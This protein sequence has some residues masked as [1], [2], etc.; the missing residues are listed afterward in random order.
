MHYNRAKFFSAVR[1]DFGSLK[2]S[3]VDGFNFI[4]D[5]W[6]TRYAYRDHRD[7]A[8]ALATTWHETGRTMQPI[9]EA[10][11]TS[12]ADSIRRLDNA[13]AKGQLGKVSKPY[14]RTGFF[15]RGYVQLTHEANYRK[16][17]EK[18]K[19]LF[20]IDVDFVNNPDLVMKPEYAVLIMFIGM[21]EGWFAGDKGG[22]H[23]FSRYFSV[24]VDDPIGARRIINGTDEA[25]KIA[26]YHV[27][28]LTALRDSQES[29]AFAPQE[30]VEA[31]VPVPAPTPAPKAPEPP[32]ALPEAPV[33]SAP[34]KEP[35]L[36]GTLVIAFGM[37]LKGK[38]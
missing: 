8:Y 7:L 37:W 25:A 36:L 11:G 5:A 4:L 28:F 27:K 33:A 21:I 18:L 35:S 6:E 22:R 26:A 29:G 2:Q 3:Q 15:G 10:Y 17:Q 13:W 16:A 1:K 38:L 12:T 9:R 23:T 14:W 20:D 31:P 19:A 24:R 34:V 32:T 30:A